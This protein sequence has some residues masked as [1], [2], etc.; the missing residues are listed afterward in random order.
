MVPGGRGRSRG[1][2]RAGLA[3]RRDA[4][5]HPLADPLLAHHAGR[6]HR[7]PNYLWLPGRPAV[8]GRPARHRHQPDRTRATGGRR[9]GGLRLVSRGF[10]LVEALV[11][12]AVLSVGLLGAAA[13]L[14]GALR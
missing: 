8:S 13:M 1:A 7:Y 11:T 12:I 5:F 10:S 9:A 6:E 2:R 4:A 3:A 14:L